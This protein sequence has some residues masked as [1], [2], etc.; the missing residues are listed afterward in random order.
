MTG[1]F[2]FDYLPKVWWPALLLATFMLL[3]KPFVFNWLLRKSGE[4]RKISWE[5]SVRLGQMSEFSLLIVY[6]SLEATLV[7]LH[8]VYTV[9]AAMILTFIVSSYWVTLRYPTPLASSDKLRR[10]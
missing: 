8:A 10:D 9:Q 1:G 2:N 5:V 7:N 4:A 6:I 3:F